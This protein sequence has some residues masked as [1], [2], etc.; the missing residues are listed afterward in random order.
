[1]R[2]KRPCSYASILARLVDDLKW[3]SDPDNVRVLYFFDS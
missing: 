3:V 1:M 2:A